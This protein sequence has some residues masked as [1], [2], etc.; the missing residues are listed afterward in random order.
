MAPLT[1]RQVSLSALPR[2]Q[3]EIDA[4]LH[5]EMISQR[6]GKVLQTR[7]SSFHLARLASFTRFFVNRDP[8]WLNRGISDATVPGLVTTSYIWPPQF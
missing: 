8:D 5:W 1:A 2:L 4:P 7:G 3:A 6:W